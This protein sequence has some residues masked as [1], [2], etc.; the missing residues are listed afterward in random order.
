MDSSPLSRLPAELRGQIAEY[1]LRYDDQ[2]IVKCTP[3]RS[4]REQGTHNNHAHPLALAQ[5][6]RLLRKECTTMVYSMNS[7]VIPGEDTDALFK[8]L[9]DFCSIIGTENEAA[10]TSIIL[11]IGTL[12][13]E[14]F[15]G[16]CCS[17]NELQRF[18]KR[19]ATEMRSGIWLCT[20]QARIRFTFRPF[21]S[22][23]GAL[24]VFKVNLDFGDI[25]RSWCANMESIRT[26]IAAEDADY[27]Q[28]VAPMLRDARKAF[29]PLLYEDGVACA[30]L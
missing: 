29:L 26:Q 10:L 4:M 25:E 16:A 2:L 28:R 23:L 19:I 17:Y 9:Q 15:E 24:G 14:S 1:A 8:G 21:I 27:W 11:D 3:P 12:E 13:L 5:T 6:C 22:D 30:E 20:F 18:M 7:F